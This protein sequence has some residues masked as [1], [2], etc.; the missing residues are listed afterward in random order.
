MPGPA[1]L[2]ELAAQRFDPT[3]EPRSLAFDRLQK[4]RP[5]GEV[6]AEPDEEQGRQQAAPAAGD[7]RRQEA[8][9]RGAQ[10]PRQGAQRRVGEDAAGVVGEEPP[11]PAGSADQER[12]DDPAAHAEAVPG[13]EQARDECAAGRDRVHCA[14]PRLVVVSAGWRSA[15]TMRQSSASTWR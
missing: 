14:G 7:L 6:E 3:P 11:P 1:R 15:P 12:A 8:G 2:Q 13:G 9:E 4:L 5:A 10:C